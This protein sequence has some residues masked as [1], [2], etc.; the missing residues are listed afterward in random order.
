MGEQLIFSEKKKFFLPLTILRDLVI[1]L[2]K[3]VMIL[4]EQLIFYEG[5]KKKL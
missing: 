2:M 1:I 4:R 5:E 3:L